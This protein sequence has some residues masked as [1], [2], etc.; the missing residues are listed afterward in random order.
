M[1][2]DFTDLN[3]A[4]PKNCYLL[5]RIDALVNWILGYEILYFLDAFKDYHQ[6]RMNEE[7]QEK[8]AFFTDQE[9]YCYTTMPFGLKNTRATYQRLVNRIF[10]FQIG[11]NVEA[12]VDDILLKSKETSAFLSD[13]RE[14]LRVLRNTR[15]MF[16]PKKCLFGVTSKKFLGYLVSRPEIE[17][18]PDKVKAIQ[19]MSLPR[20]V[21]EVQRLKDLLAAGIAFCLNLLRRLYYFSRC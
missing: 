9:I 20:N 18:N 7:Y 15:M 8:T 6:M 2:L 5:S 4:C 17:A 19:D 16:N 21:Q 11:R 13:V 3:K 12:Y 10:K 14:V 1:C